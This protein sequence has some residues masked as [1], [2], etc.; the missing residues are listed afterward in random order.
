M[1]EFGLQPTQFI[2]EE[3]V[4]TKGKTKLSAFAILA[5]SLVLALVHQLAQRKY[6]PGA[7]DTEIK[8]G[9]TMR[10]TVRPRPTRPSA[11]QRWDSLKLAKF[12]IETNGGQYV[13]KPS[14]RRKSAILLTNFVRLVSASPSNFS[15]SILMGV[16][17]GELEGLAPT[18]IFSITAPESND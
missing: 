14:V 1:K 6:A 12:R 18:L 16:K 7:S 13:E 3:A 10:S 8:I 11:R 5:A 4:M 17:T 15:G 2:F 9:Q